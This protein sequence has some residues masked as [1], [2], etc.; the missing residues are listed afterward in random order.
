MF[1]IKVPL[2]LLCSILQASL[3]ALGAKFSWCSS[4]GCL[5][6]DVLVD[7]YSYQPAAGYK[8]AQAVLHWCLGHCWLWD[9]WCKEHRNHSKVFKR[10]LGVKIKQRIMVWGFLVSFW[11]HAIHLQFQISFH[12]LLQK[13]WKIYIFIAKVKKKNYCE[14]RKF[15]VVWKCLP[16][17]NMSLILHS[18]IFHVIAFCSIKGENNCFFI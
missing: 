5:R 2:I 16:F 3:F 9:L 18:K 10:Q 14:S 13:K 17:L 8:A 6:E 11:K 12:I 4:K 15:A 1:W 7:G